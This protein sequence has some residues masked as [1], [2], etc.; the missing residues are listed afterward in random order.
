MSTTKL[1]NLTVK[2]HGTKIEYATKGIE[3]TDSITIYEDEKRI[4][5]ELA[6]VTVISV[7]DYEIVNTISNETLK[8]LI[9]AYKAV[10]NEILYA[11]AEKMAYTH[12]KSNDIDSQMTRSF[13]TIWIRVGTK[14]KY[15][16]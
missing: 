16:Y 1:Y 7:I 8:K 11:I 12:H 15:D 14:I 5:D 2:R 13:D 6:C 3:I 4:N 9:E 10:N